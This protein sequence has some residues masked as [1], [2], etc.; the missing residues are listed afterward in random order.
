MKTMKEYVCP[1]CGWTQTAHH[2]Y[3][4]QW[5]DSNAVHVHVHQLCPALQENK[6]EE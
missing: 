6:D 2:F 4:W 1:N 5:H 3:G